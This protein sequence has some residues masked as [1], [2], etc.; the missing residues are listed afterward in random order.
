MNPH[1]NGSGVS[2]Q[3][4]LMGVEV[5][6][7][8]APTPK[9]PRGIPADA[10]VQLMQAEFEK[11]HEAI[12]G[13]AESISAID[14]RT[15]EAAYVPPSVAITKEVFTTIEAAPLL[16][17]KPYTVREWCRLGRINAEKGDSGRGADNEWRITLE[18]INRF[19]NEGLLPLQPESA[20]RP[21]RRKP[22]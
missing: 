16:K 10:V 7:A 15:K 14:E 19:L 13:I 2:R 11:L 1:Q 4:F 21:R 20:I 22:R 9:R 5:E 3:Q 18:E 17:R 8:P 12:H 6:P